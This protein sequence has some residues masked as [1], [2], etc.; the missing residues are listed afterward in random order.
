MIAA[1]FRPVR[2]ESTQWVP[3]GAAAERWRPGDILL[4]RGHSWFG[5][6]IRFG[7]GLR[8]HGQ[9]RQYTWCSHAALVVGEA[10]ELVEVGSKGARRADA[11]KYQRQ[12]YAV[13]HTG[14]D[15]DDLKQMLAFAEWVLE[16]RPRYGYATIVSIGLTVLT[17]S[18][19]A[20]FVSGE[21]ICSGFVARAME[22]AGAIFSRDSVH[23]SPAD[24][25]K[26]YGVGP[27]S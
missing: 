2:A 20:F 11:S 16:S 24:L 18:K 10:G 14:V 27:P 25:A 5:R 8:I 15:T 17:G 19:F 26:Y 1:E 21:F 3:A 12:D 7:Q 9:D 6:L 4:T 13:V 22:R 23:I